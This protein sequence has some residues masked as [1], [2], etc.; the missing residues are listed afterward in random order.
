[1]KITVI[2]ATFNSA[3]TLGD[4]LDSV[5]QQ[6]F[7]DIEHVVIDGASKDGTLALLAARR[8]D[9]AVLVSEPDHGI[10]DALNKGIAMATG[11]IIGFLHSDD[12]YPSTDVLAKVAQA[13]ADRQVDAVYGDL[14]YVSKRHASKVIRRWKA[15]QFKRR[16]LFLGWMPPHPT[17]F[18]RRGIYAQIGGFDTRFRI[19]ADYDSVLRMFSRPGFR[20]VYLPW[21]MV[22]MRVGGVSNRSLANILHKSRQ[23]LAAL[24]HT[25]VGGVFSLL[26]KNL[27]KIPQFFRPK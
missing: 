19:A 4:C 22:R 16:D 3:K 8:D 2:T 15:G 5:R 6:S 27:R 1:M 20:A 7:R 13:F 10:Y 21:V 26:A 14:E 12:F 23:D 9:I 11:D 17:L 18:V 24:R 25:G